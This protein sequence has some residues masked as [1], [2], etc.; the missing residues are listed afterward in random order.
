[1]TGRNDAGKTTLLEAIFL[2]VG[3]ANARMA[4]QCAE[5]AGDSIDRPDKARARAY[6]AMK[7]DQ[8]VSVGV[9]ARKGYWNFDH[10]AF[11]G[12]RGF[13]TSLAQDRPAV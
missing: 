1:M 5:E 3:A 4:F 9:A 13:L 2:L 12:V 8:H 11:D 6:L 10:D 7:P